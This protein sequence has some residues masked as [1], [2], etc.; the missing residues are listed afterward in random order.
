MKKLL[1]IVVL[2]LLWCNVGFANNDLTGIKLLC[3]K[4]SKWPFNSRLF[5]TYEFL[6]DFK[7][8]VHN[9]NFNQLKIR[10]N[11]KFYKADLRVVYLYYSENKYKKHTKDGETIERDTLILSQFRNQKDKGTHSCSVVDKDKDLKKILENE[12]EIIKSKILEK[13]KI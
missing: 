11:E 3:K 9:L 4:N 1:G 13:N 8:S 5:T 7:V 2:G 10:S 6:N 12:L